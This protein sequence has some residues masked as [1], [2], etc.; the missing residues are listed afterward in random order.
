MRFDTKT[1]RLDINTSDE[2]HAQLSRCVNGIG[3]GM[4]VEIALDVGTKLNLSA[5]PGF[6]PGRRIYPQ[7]ATPRAEQPAVLGGRLAGVLNR[8]KT[9]TRPPGTRAEL[10]FDLPRDAVL[11]ATEWSLREGLFPHEALGEAI[12]TSLRNVEHRIE[13]RLGPVQSIGA[14]VDETLRRRVYRELHSS[15]LDPD[16][17]VAGEFLEVI[18][19]RMT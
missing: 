9:P 8:L 6:K 11:Q 17:V 10:I 3:L 16:A 5:P 7:V 4:F 13:G 12:E 18:R 2:A 1:Y 15:G 14:P 19:R